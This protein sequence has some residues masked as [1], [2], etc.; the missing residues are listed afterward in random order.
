M[1]VLLPPANIKLRVFV[2]EAQLA[3][4][5]LGE[6][7]QVF[8][9]GVGESVPATVNFI[10]P[11]AEYSPPMIYSR[12][13]REKFVYLIEAAFE[14]GIAARLHPGQPVEVVLPVRH[15]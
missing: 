6:V 8:M 3:P 7:V 14:G 10:S 1:V 5:Q 13:N 11:R 9:D 4:L 2:P 12:A 15:P